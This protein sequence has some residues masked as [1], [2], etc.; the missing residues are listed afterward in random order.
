M[1]SML[2]I[3]P[4]SPDILLEDGDHLAG[5]GLDAK[6]MHTP[7]HTAGSSAL[8]LRP[9]TLFAGDLLSATGRPHLQRYF[10][11]DWSSLGSSLARV[12]AEAPLLVYAGH[13]R[14]PIRSEMLQ[15][16]GK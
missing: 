16:L 4:T 11:Q 3:E 2:R 14:T 1:Q 6:V 10:A 7:G 5:H 8:F 12:Q 13:G 9:S 15:K